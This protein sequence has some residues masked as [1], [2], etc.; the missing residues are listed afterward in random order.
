M[1]EAW[2]SKI[3]IRSEM[4]IALNGILTD[5]VS[6]TVYRSIDEKNDKIVRDMQC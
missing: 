2:I 1:T 3:G 6:M 4:E 5:E